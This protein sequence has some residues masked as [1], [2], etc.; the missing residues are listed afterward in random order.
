LPALLKL[1]RLDELPAMPLPVAREQLARTQA[2]PAT[3]GIEEYALAALRLLDAHGPAGTLHTAWQTWDKAQPILLERLTQHSLELGSLLTPAA[4]PPNSTDPNWNTYINIANEW[5]Q[6]GQRNTH[7]LQKNLLQAST[8]AR[9]PH[10]YLFWRLLTL[11]TTSTDGRT[12]R[13]LWNDCLRAEMTYGRSATYQTSLNLRLLLA[14]DD[15]TQQQEIASDLLADLSSAG[16]TYTQATTVITNL[17]LPYLPYLPNKEQIISMLCNT[18]RQSNAITPDTLFA[19]YSVLTNY[20]EI[21]APTQHIV[22]QTLAI[23]KQ[24]PLHLEQRQ[25]VSAIERLITQPSASPRPL[26][27][28]AADARAEAIYTLSQKPSH[29]LTG[30]EAEEILHA[31]MDTRNISEGMH[32]KLVGGWGISSVAQVAWKALEQQWSLQP[33]AVA[34]LLRRLR[35]QEA[36]LCAA[37]ARMIKTHSRYFTAKA[38]TREAATHTIIDILNDEVLSRRPLDT[39]DYNVWRLDDVLF[40]TLQALVER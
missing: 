1:A 29:K 27:R 36:L 40:A 24:H 4:F 15:Q 38:E 23:M 16:K 37:A 3:L 39:P 10:A 13:T 20:D 6:R 19:L 9:Y 30:A 28:V 18:L 26:P 34:V 5:Q 2:R 17:Y 8:A 7:E 22:Q 14:K 11:E 12:W 25:L 31:C 35:D 33:D 21:P 32:G